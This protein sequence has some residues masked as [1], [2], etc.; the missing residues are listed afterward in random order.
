MMNLLWV[1][2]VLKFRIRWISFMGAENS[3]AFPHHSWLLCRHWKQPGVSTPFVIIV[4]TLILSKG[5]EAQEVESN[6]RFENFGIAIDMKI[7]N[8]YLQTLIRWTTWSVVNWKTKPQKISEPEINH[9]SEVYHKTPL[10]TDESDAE[11][12]QNSE[13]GIQK[14]RYRRWRLL[15]NPVND[16][17]SDEEV[18][19]HSEL[20]QQNL[21]FLLRSG[22]WCRTCSWK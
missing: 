22:T 18:V 5:V 12:A 2:R 10:M 1:T 8:S 7:R 11:N 4:P 19:L 6:W 9:T 3:Q 17:D 15:A 13:S 14:R 21:I 16:S 20:N